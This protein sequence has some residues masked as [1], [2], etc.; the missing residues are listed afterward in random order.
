[1]TLETPGLLG[2][3]VQLMQEFSKPLLSSCQHCMRAGAGIDTLAP[4]PTSMC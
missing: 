3:T 2:Q 1:M 4:L